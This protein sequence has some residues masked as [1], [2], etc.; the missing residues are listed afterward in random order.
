[1]SRITIRCPDWMEEGISR[2]SDA[3]DMSR[4]EVIRRAVTEL[5]SE[6]GDELP[7]WVLKEASHDE[8][9]ARN[10]PELR[11]MHFEQR[12]FEYAKNALTNQ[13]G[14]VARYPPDPEMLEEHY[15]EMIREEVEE[16]YEQ[17]RERFEEH[18]DEVMGWY[19]TM[20]PDT[21]HG[22]VRHQA[23]TKCAWHIRHG[24]E[25]QARTVAQAAVGEATGPET[26]EHMI[27]DDA[28][29]K[30]TENERWVHKQDRSVQTVL[31]DD[32]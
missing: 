31:T 26:T 24:R 17:Y 16:E 6:W 20:H 18:I 23:V 5:I 4:S 19:R 8:M 27:L 11:M 22:T 21:S 25:P 28:R 10:R 29:N 7:D 30:A 12:A 1:M 32:D 9:V 2:L 14:Q 15:G 3:S 13:Q